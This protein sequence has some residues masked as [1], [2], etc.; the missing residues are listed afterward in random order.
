MPTGRMAQYAPSAFAGGGCNVTPSSTEGP[1]FLDK[2][3]IRQDITEGK[4]GVPTFLFLQV[5]DAQNG[6]VPVP[7]AVVDVWQADALGKYSGFAVEGTAGETFLRGVQF[8]DLNGIVLFQTI[9]PGLYPGRTTHI[10]FKV[11]PSLSSNIEFTG[12]LYY[13]NIYAQVINQKL[14]PYSSNP[15]PPFDNEQDGIFNSGSGD[16]TVMTT[17][18]VG[19]QGSEVL[20]TGLQLGIVLT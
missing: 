8:T 7:N 9:F 13:E 12:Q 3:L 14:A 11:R 10:H 20:V 1:Y 2:Q 18:V 16:E 17:F 5:L 15:T 6:C 19:P 4:E